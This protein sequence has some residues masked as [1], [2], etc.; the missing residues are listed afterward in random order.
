M[1]ACVYAELSDHINQLTVARLH[2]APLVS[3]AEVLE[4]WRQ[5]ALQSNVCPG[6]K[7]ATS[8]LIFTARR[9]AYK[10]GLCCRPVSVRLS[11]C[12]VGGLYPHG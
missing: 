1:P 3:A 8:D 9:N 2:Q 5:R 12:H 10:R 11:V 7:S 6:H 4:S